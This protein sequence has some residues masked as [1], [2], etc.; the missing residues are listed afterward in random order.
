LEEA[1]LARWGHA[2]KG[3]EAVQSR[4]VFDRVEGPRHR[5]DLSLRPLL[6]E[7]RLA[8]WPHGLIGQSFDGDATPRQGKQDDYN[9]P[10]V[11]TT[12][13]AEG[14]I[15]GV[16]D[17]YR[18]ASPFVT[19]FRFSRFDPLPSGARGPAPMAPDPPCSSSPRRTSPP[20]RPWCRPTPWRPLPWCRPTPRRPPPQLSV[21]PSSPRSDP[22]LPPASDRD[23]CV[24]PSKC[25]LTQHRER[26]AAREVDRYERAA[27]LKSA[28][29]VRH[30]AA[31]QVD[32]P[33]RGAPPPCREPLLVSGVDHR[34]R[35]G[36]RLVA[37]V[38]ALAADWV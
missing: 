14:A 36:A 1:H 28:R 22:P 27:R 18:V 16:A 3:Q 31:G 10:V 19:E 17:D 29:E 34:R 8:E 9:A 30:R 33:Q 15:E 13:Q 24:A 2:D 6:P 21:Q 32:R 5:L 11:W 38:E 25:G 23:E 4:P 35:R 26:R 37:G 20:P 7:A 12:A